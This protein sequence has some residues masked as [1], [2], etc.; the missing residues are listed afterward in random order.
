MENCQYFF[1]CKIQGIAMLYRG[2]QRVEMGSENEPASLLLILELDEIGSDI[3]KENE[4]FIL[5]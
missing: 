3:K 1:L 5:S 2:R 4:E